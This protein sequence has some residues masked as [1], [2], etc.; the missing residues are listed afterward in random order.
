MPIRPFDHVTRQMMQPTYYLW[1]RQCHAK[2]WQSNDAM[3]RRCQLTLA[4][5]GVG[6]NNIHSIRFK[7]KMTKATWKQHKFE[8]EMTNTKWKYKLVSTRMLRLLL[9]K[10]MRRSPVHNSSALKLAWINCFHNSVWSDWHWV[11]CNQHMI[12]WTTT[13]SKLWISKQKTCLW[14]V[15]AFNV[16]PDE[17]R[18]DLSAPN[19]LR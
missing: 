5:L 11:Q 18:H 8:I 15:L 14:S 12:S 19:N 1:T 13:I 7:L 2:Q 9:A 4:E 10:F 6:S 16:F 17:Q 3:K